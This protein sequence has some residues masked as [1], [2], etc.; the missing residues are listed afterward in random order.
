MPHSSPNEPVIGGANP[1]LNADSQVS[2]WP[3]TG[4]LSQRDTFLGTLANP[5]A[6]ENNCP[7]IVEGIELE[8]S[9]FDNVVLALWADKSAIS[10]ELHESLLQTNPTI[11]FAPKAIRFPMDPTPQTVKPAIRIQPVHDGEDAVFNRKKPTA[12][13]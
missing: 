2:S 6:P 8:E 9:Q 7:K 1:G 10:K 4:L 3:P 12:G 5:A 13:A 11:R